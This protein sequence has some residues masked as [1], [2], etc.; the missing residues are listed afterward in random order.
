LNNL[1]TKISSINDITEKEW[2][3]RL[4]FTDKEISWEMLDELINNFIV[5]C[6]LVGY[7]IRTINK[8]NKIKVIWIEFEE[9]VAEEAYKNYYK[10]CEENNNNEINSGTEKT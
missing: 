8:Y 4:R 1:F 9:D 7:H 3:N 5:Y 6:N 10:L 2:A